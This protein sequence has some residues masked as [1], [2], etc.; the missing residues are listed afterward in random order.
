MYSPYSRFG[1][2]ELKVVNG[3][4]SADQFFM[5]PNS[6]VILMDSSS[7]RFYIKETDASGFAKVTAYDF[8]EV[9]EEPKENDYITKAQFEELIKQ[10]ELNTKRTEVEPTKPTS[11]PLQ[12]KF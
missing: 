8:T 9:K 3:R 12:T 6:R 4:A 1:G 10:Y 2:D 5:Y 7:D 11:V